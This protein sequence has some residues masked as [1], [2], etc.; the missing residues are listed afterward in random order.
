M[1]KLLLMMLM[2]PAFLSAAPAQQPADTCADGTVITEKDLE[3]MA[4]NLERFRSAVLSGN[5]GTVRSLL[6]SGVSPNV[7]LPNGDTP[8]TYAFRSDAWSVVEALIESEATD[9]NMQNQHGETPI[10]LAVF[11]N[12][13]EDFEK[14]LRRGATVKKELGWTP[15]HYAA[16]EAHIG[17]LKRIIELGAD[18]NAQTKAG[19]TA[20]DMA[21]RKPSREAVMVLLRA[22]AYRDYCTDA[23]LSP[24]D[25]ARNAGDEELAK[26]LAIPKCAVKGPARPELYGLVQTP[27]LLR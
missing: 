14:L 6:N 8:L 22:G 25:F 24:A 7:I 2:A 11:K 15:L 21:A 20:L 23:G 5:A 4:K 13:T 27:S 10:M 9:V 18:V 26:Y 3:E 17:L 1:R 16:T 12:R 19:V